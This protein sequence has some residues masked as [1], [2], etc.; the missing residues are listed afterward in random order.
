M[1]TTLCIDPR[2]T[3][4]EPSL[5]NTL[6]KISAEDVNTASSLM[7][8]WPDYT[9]ISNEARRGYVQWLAGGRKES[10]A[11]IGYVFLNPRIRIS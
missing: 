5:I 9:S 4:C 2:A 6:L 10:G 1:Y 8:Y 7:T 3:L 11:D